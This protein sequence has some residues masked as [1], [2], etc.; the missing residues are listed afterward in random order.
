VKN[1]VKMMDSKVTIVREVADRSLFEM[2]SAG[3]FGSPQFITALWRMSL[4]D[5][6]LKIMCTA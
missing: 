6:K 2:I 3:Q 4:R 1:K 5:T